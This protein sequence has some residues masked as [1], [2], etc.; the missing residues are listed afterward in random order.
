MAQ[1][2]EVVSS[3]TDP[4]EAIENPLILI[5]VLNALAYNYKNFLKISLETPNGRIPTKS[6]V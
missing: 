1:V 3:F 4:V 5:N 2:R 6:S